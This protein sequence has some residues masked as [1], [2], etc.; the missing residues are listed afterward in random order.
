MTRLESIF[1][2]SKKSGKKILVV[3]IPA[4]VPDTSTTRR[5]FNEVIDVGADIVILGIPFSESIADNH[6]LMRTAS[7]VAIKNGT[8][9]YRV[10]SLIKDYRRIT[11]APII[12]RAYINNLIS[13]GFKF[14][15]DY[16]GFERF[17][18]EAKIAGLDG[19]ILAD[20]P[21][22]ESEPFRQVCI[23][24]NIRL[25]DS[26]LQPPFSETKIVSTELIEFLLNGD[27]AGAVSLVRST[28]EKLDNV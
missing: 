17:V 18:T 9:A 16:N 22:D 12:V 26:V 7:K 1:E 11:D 6:P 14:G 27:V 8:S 20:V 23:K 2:R 19:L 24:K 3:Y 21:L 10:V 5:F 15:N 13:Y 28:R 25:I 4:G